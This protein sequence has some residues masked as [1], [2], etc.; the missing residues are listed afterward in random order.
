MGRIESDLL[1]RDIEYLVER[2]FIIYETHW[3][4]THRKLEG[5]F[6]KVAN[7]A[8]KLAHSFDNQHHEA[9][10][11]SAPSTSPA[12]PGNN[13]FTLFQNSSYQL[14]DKES[15]RTSTATHYR[16]DDSEHSDGSYTPSRDESSAKSPSVFSETLSIFSGTSRST[17]NPFRDHVSKTRVSKEELE[18]KLVSANIWDDPLA[19]SLI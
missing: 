4:R 6:N 16:H 12:Y 8:P 5:H 11:P 1:Q 19:V 9:H 3:R 18:P 7:Q 13:D 15:P 14:E 10:Q 2:S 17:N